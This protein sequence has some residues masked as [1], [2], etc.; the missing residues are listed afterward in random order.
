MIF[1]IKKTIR[2]KLFACPEKNDK[3]KYFYYFSTISL[4]LSK[5]TLIFGQIFSSPSNA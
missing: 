5:A 1:R 3:L 2:G 4:A